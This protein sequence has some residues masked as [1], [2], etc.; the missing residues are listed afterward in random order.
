MTVS[1]VIDIVFVLIACIFII[2]YARKGFFKTALDLVKTAVAILLAYFLRNQVAKIFDTLFMNRV[3]VNWVNKSLT[4]VASGDNAVVDFVSIYEDMPDFYNKILSK[5]G[6]NAEGLAEQF[7]NLT[8]E[9][10]EKLSVNV[11][12]AVSN[13]LSVILAVIVVFAVAII[14]LTIVVHFLNLLTKFKGVDVINKLLGLVFGAV[15][16]FA[17]IW[18]LSFLIS[19]GIAMFGPMYPNI[20]NEEIIDKSVILKFFC[21]SDLWN[22]LLGWLGKV[23]Q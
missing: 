8:E 2:R 9:N 23:K 6:I 11:G 15:F 16:A 5:F 10:I 12:S 13:M 4:S 21:R 1:L 18:G 20:I 7:G 3:I 22:T 19:K 17:V 14:V